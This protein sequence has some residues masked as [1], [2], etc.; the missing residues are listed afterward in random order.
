MIDNVP[1][2]CIIIPV[3][4]HHQVIQSLVNYI[5][6]LPL[7]IFLIDDGGDEVCR[8][9]LQRVSHASSLVSLL[10]H[11]NNEGKGRAVANGM[12]AAFE[13]GFTHAL[14]IDADG[15]HSVE[16]ILTFIEQCKKYPESVIAGAR[17]Y[18][19]MPP[20]RRYGR[21]VTDIWVWINTLSTRIKDSMCGYRL[22]PLAQTV[23]FLDQYTVRPRMDF[24]T[25]ILVR[26][27]WFGLDVKH[28]DVKVSY[29][30]E[31][32]HF[33]VWKDNYRISKMHARLFFGMLARLP[34]ILMLNIKG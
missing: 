20:S 2:I 3:Y 26:L 21:K 24:D 15:Q 14:Q 25:D 33:N 32:S 12:R 5:E 9:V 10:V 34:K 19:D 23:A 13:S 27:Y 28:I 17:R 8:N 11:K 22:Y 31:T 7:P 1:K 4:N 30:A 18:E 29:G 16:Y 6:A